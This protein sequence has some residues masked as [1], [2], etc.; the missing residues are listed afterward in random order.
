MENTG[1]ERAAPTEQV[2][3]ATVQHPGTGVLD[4]RPESKDVASRHPKPLEEYK[5]FVLT[6]RGR[7][8]PQ[9]VYRKGQINFVKT[10]EGKLSPVRAWRMKV[11]DQRSV[12]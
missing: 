6:S 7:I 2:N 8:S 10:L 12:V 5:H 3:P 9:A 1:T 11:K 4:Q